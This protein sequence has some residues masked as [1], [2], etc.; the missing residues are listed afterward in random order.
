MYFSFFLLL[1]KKINYISW[2]FSHFSLSHLRTLS[3]FTLSFSSSDLPWPFA[4]LYET[5]YKTL[6]RVKLCW[7]E[8]NKYHQYIL[9]SAHLIKAPCLLI[10]I[11]NM[12]VS[13][14]HIS[15]LF[16]PPE[17]IVTRILLAPIPGP[18]FLCLRE[19]GD[20][21]AGSFQLCS[22][23]TPGREK[24]ARKLLQRRVFVI[25]DL[26]ELFCKFCGHGK[27]ALAH[28]HTRGHDRACTNH[29]YT[30]QTHT[31]TLLQITKNLPHIPDLKGISWI[32]SL[33]Q[34]YLKKN[35]ASNASP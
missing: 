4:L 1:T 11:F 26:G 21:S 19:I 29:R 12:F 33:D 28:V 27:E 34:N 6:F 10:L 3:A 7:P 25:W 24:E 31:H 35:A 5:R 18:T 13:D 16:R 2:C 22:G 23:S 15:L 9:D 30:S 14:W 32:V 8:Q 20:P 17:R